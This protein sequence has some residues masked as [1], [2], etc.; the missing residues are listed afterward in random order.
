[1]QDSMLL[2]S[3][4]AAFVATCLENIVESG[5]LDN[6]I[7]YAREHSEDEGMDTEGLMKFIDKLEEK[8]LSESEENKEWQKILKIINETT[9]CNV[10]G[11]KGDRTVMIENEEMTD[12]EFNNYIDDDSKTAKIN[13]ESINK[14]LS[15]INYKLEFYEA[16][17]LPFEADGFHNIIRFK[18]IKIEQ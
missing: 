4:R 8:Y 1:M 13:I 12:D 14:A 18:V 7:E 3:F 15:A 17:G 5:N 6:F 11:F 10:Q 16:V 2:K 9:G